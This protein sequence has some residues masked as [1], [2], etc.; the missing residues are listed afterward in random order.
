MPATEE[1]KEKHFKQW[2]KDEEQKKKYKKEARERKI[3]EF[4]RLESE[5]KKD[6]LI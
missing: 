2:Q 1:D 5:L 3:K 4:K 6:G